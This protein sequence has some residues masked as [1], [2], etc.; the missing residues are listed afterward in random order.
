MTA[1]T[2]HRLRHEGLLVLRWGRGGPDPVVALHG[3]TGHGLSFENLGRAVAHGGGSLWAPVLPGHDPLSPP[4]EG[5]GFVD[6]ARR[7]GRILEAMLDEPCRLVGYSMG[8]RVALVLAL[9]RPELVRALLLVGVHPGL[10]PAARE[11]RRAEERRWQ[12]RLRDQGLLAFLSWWESRPLFASQ[13]RLDPGVR[14]RQNRLR[15]RH[16]AAALAGAL[17]T[18]GLGVMPACLGRI[19]TMNLPMHLAVGEDDRK[20][21]DL[22]RQ[23]ARATDGRATLEVVPGAGHNLVLEHPE[24]LLRWM[25]SRP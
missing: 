19:G 11:R 22:G 8:A 20:F 5:E 17:D 10:E 9:E 25:E 3:F 1:P 23:I 6:A 14:G 16:R 15:R 2:I 13:A 7:L 4:L 12:S 24:L 21:V 18:L